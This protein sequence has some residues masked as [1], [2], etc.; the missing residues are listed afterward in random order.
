[1]REGYYELAYKAFLPCL[2]KIL[3]EALDNETYKYERCLLYY[4]WGI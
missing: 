4:Y 1:M 2:E 3:E